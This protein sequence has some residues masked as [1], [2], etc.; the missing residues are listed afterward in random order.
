MMFV[1]ERGVLSFPEIRLGA[2][3]PF[4]TALLIDRLP[5]AL[6]EELLLTGRE[7][8]AADAVRWGLANRVV[9]HGRMEDEVVSFAGKSILPFSAASLRIATKAIRIPAERA[10]NEI[11]LGSNAERLASME[12]LY[13]DELVP[14][15]DAREG[16][17][18]FLEKRYPGWRNR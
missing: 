2:F 3:A 8:S 1:D 10:G 5:R 4:G 14:L 13:L 18:A 15:E 9:A 12:R 16:I 6:V 11:D 7:L 17:R